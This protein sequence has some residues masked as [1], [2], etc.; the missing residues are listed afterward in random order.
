MLGVF[1]TLVFRIS[2]KVRKVRDYK[3]Y[4]QEVEER[5]KSL[6]VIG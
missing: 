2:N 6:E 1:V 3:K 4:K 5:I